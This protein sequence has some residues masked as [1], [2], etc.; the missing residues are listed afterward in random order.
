M[1]KVTLIKKKSSSDD[2]EDQESVVIV[3]FESASTDLKEA[4]DGSED[5]KTKA[6]YESILSYLNIEGLNPSQNVSYNNAFLYAQRAYD[7]DSDDVV[8]THNLALIYF[9]MRDYKKAEPLFIKCVKTQ[10]SISDYDKATCA[11]KLGE[12]TSTTSITT[13]LEVNFCTI[14]FTFSISCPRLPIITPGR[15]VFILILTF[16]DD[17]LS[18]STSATVPS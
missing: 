3:D 10:K 11:S 18:T 9:N 6:K 2:E 12:C 1:S 17:T 14:V 7:H 15:D 8:N 16:S 13:S 5:D 4:I